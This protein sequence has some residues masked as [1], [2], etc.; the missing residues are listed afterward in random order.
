VAFNPFKGAILDESQ[1]NSFTAEVHQFHLRLLAGRVGGN[2]VTAAAVLLL[3]QAITG[4]V[5][6]WPRMAVGHQLEP[7]LGRAETTAIQDRPLETLPLAG[8][9]SGVVF[10]G[11][12]SYRGAWGNSGTNPTL[13]IPGQALAGCC[14]LPSIVSC[15]FWISRVKGFRWFA[16]SF[17]LRAE[18]ITWGAFVVAGM[19]VSGDWL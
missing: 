1:R 10:R 11:R 15:G 5:L 4:L 13:R 3:V 2:I 16:V 8:Y 19:S 17:L 18:V 12:N 14:D 7:Y 9:K 6:W